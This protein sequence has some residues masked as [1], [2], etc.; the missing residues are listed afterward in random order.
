LSFVHLDFD[1]IIENCKNIVARFYNP[2][3]NVFF[4][5][6][7]SVSHNQNVPEDIKVAKAKHFIQDK[8]V[9]CK[10][11]LNKHVSTKLPSN[12]LPVPNFPT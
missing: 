2:S 8:F 9:V 6:S 1:L 12:E 7:G 5:I 4:F 11:V 10:F 3:L